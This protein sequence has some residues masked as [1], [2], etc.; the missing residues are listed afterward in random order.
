MSYLHGRDE[1]RQAIA[2]ALSSRAAAELGRSETRLSG[3][4]AGEGVMSFTVTLAAHVLTWCSGLARPA[5]FE[6]ATRCLEGTF[7]PSRDVA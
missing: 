2:D 4:A 5:G 6:P 7:E 3:T 1:R